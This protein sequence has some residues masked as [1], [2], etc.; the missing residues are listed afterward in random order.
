M[1]ATVLDEGLFAEES[2]LSTPLLAAGQT[3]KE[4]ERLILSRIPALE[5]PSS[6][7][8]WRVRAGE[9]RKNVL[10][11]AVFRGWPREIVE[12]K[13]GARYLDQKTIETGKGYRIR[14]LLYEPY[15]GLWIPALLYEPERLALA[16]G[17]KV[18]AVLVVNGHVGPPGKTVDY[19]QIQCINLA[20]RGMIALNPEWFSYGELAGGDYWHNGI[21][22]LE[23]CG[24]S[25][26]ALFYLALRGAVDVLLDHPNAD[27]DRVAVTGLSG[28][29]WQTIFLAALDERVKACAPNA[30]YIGL[31]T[32]LFHAGDVGDLEQNP[33]DLLLAADYT[34]LT[35][36]LVPRP[37]LLIYN[38]RDDCCFAAAR[39]RESVF[40][41]VVPFYRRFAPRVEFSFHENEWPGDHN[42]GL[43]N[44]Q[45]FYRFVNRLWV[46][47]GE[48][49]DGEIP[50]DGE[51]RTF[52]DLK[53]GVPEGNATIHSIAME[54][55]KDLPR[56]RA[57][58][59]GNDPERCSRLRSVLRETLRMSDAKGKPFEAARAAGTPGGWK[60]A[61]ESGITLPVD[62]LGA[63]KA[64]V[65][66]MVSDEGRAAV[67]D[68]AVKLAG[69]GG[70]VL[71]ADLLFTGECRPSRL[72]VGQHVMLLSNVG[73]R[74]LGE[75]AAEVRGLCLWASSE[76]GAMEVTIEARGPVTATAVLVAAALGDM[77]RGAGRFQRA[78]L[79][80]LPKSFKGL[81]Q[82]G[83]SIDK[84]QQL[85]AFGLLELV[86]V[87]ELLALAPPG[88]V[89]VKD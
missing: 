29:G 3:E 61:L 82:P 49:I 62:E 68:T 60:V 71:A 1:A 87:P 46:L 57:A 66:I 30:G 15:P 24:R 23:L 59:L 88:V 45:A 22:C 13:A 74:S 5:I 50:C 72:N 43:D 64:A 34:H 69:A 19:K 73:V 44:R 54:I 8:E 81:I 9:I 39:A 38:A 12:R 76:L 27:A 14:K 37:A 6:G 75:M 21:V 32:R 20:K 83:P 17:L 55:A 33:A 16:R 26:V 84:A 25:G 35:A 58:E 89:D 70:C 40:V 56:Y 53:V 7:E 65:T 51:V 67:R 77:P 47:P 86:D 48:R 28:G 52:E 10:D 79:H 41:P 42:Y 78:S 80:G 36:L 4:L 18:P 2:A 11:H 85:F 63:R 31:A